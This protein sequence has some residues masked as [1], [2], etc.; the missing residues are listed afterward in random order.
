MWAC[1]MEGVCTAA[2]H[3]SKSTSSHS[4][5][6]QAQSGAPHNG[7]AMPRAAHGPVATHGTRPSTPRGG[8]PFPAVF[9]TEGMLCP[10][11][12]HSET[13]CVPGQSSLGCCPCGAPICGAAGPCRTSLEGDLHEACSWPPNGHHIRPT[14]EWKPAPTARCGG[15]WCGVPKALLPEG[16]GWDVYPRVHINW[17]G[18][19]CHV[20]PPVSCGF[21]AAAG[22]VRLP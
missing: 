5:C 22:A 6:A 17:G 9:H 3:C 8:A 11:P 1:F 13:T 21:R 20:W 10:A 18:C 4:W 7:Q 14:P 19:V 2:A 12:C 15:V 16:N